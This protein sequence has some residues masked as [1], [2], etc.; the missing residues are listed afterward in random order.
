MDDGTSSCVDHSDDG[1]VID[2]AFVESV[3]DDVNC[4]DDEQ[5]LGTHSPHD[6]PKS[7]EHGGNC[8]G[9]SDQGDNVDLDDGIAESSVEDLVPEVFEE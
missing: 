2:N 3:A 5:V 9:A 7:Y 1:G 4:T 8:I 6:S